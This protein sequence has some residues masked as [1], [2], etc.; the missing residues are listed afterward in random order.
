MAEMWAGIPADRVMAVVASLDT[1]Q[2]QIGS[3]YL[4]TERLVLT[5]SHCAMD[6]KTGRPATKLQVACRSGGT[7]ATATLLAAQS[8]LDVVCSLWRTRRGPCRSLRIRPGSG[9]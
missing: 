2:V 3:G 1:G 4:V 5:A 7:E 9:G 6:K 8:E